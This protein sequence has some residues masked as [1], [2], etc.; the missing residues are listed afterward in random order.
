VLDSWDR[1]SVIFRVGVRRRRNE[2]TLSPHFFTDCF[3]PGS[4]HF[5]PRSCASPRLCWPSRMVP[6]RQHASHKAE[7]GHQSLDRGALMVGYFAISQWLS[8]PV[9]RTV[10][11]GRPLIGIERLN[12]SHGS[13]GEKVH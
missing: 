13:L 5:P 2:T 1:T 3:Y 8:F 7:S 11:V 6:K 4:L 12:L 9:S 10:C